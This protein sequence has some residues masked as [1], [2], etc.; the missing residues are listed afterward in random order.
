MGGT[1]KKYRLSK[2][3]NKEK[4]WTILCVGAS[5]GISSFKL[6]KRALITIGIFVGLVLFVTIAA[7]LTYGIMKDENINLRSS[8]EAIQKKLDQTNQE[9]EDLTAQLLILQEDLSSKEGEPKPSTTEKEPTRLAPKPL[10]A[11]VAKRAENT[12]PTVLPAEGTPQTISPAVQK[13]PPVGLELIV[14]NFNLNKDPKTKQVRYNFLLK[15]KKPKK[16][17]VSGYTFVLLKPVKEDATSWR[18]SP[19]R[20]F[21]AGKSK[22]FNMGRLFSI[23][24]FKI[25][26]G[27][28]PDT[29]TIDAWEEAVVLV[30]SS[31]GELILEKEF[32]YQTEKS[33]PKTSQETAETSHS[34]ATVTTR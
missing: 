4:Q 31:S 15:H 2:S 12:P 27:V 21:Q 33:R 22:K 28:I 10:E 26:Q 9:K 17:A 19:K 29:E 14:E 34:E 18:I 23:V 24:R 11:A 25:V 1:L 16:K 6:S 30:Y 20:G 13:N 3:E 5:G 32:E 8:L 7:V